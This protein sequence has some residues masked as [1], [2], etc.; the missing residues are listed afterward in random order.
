MGVKKCVHLSDL[1]A[2][3]VSTQNGDTVLVAQ[4]KADE[5]GDGLNRI[6]TAIHIITHEEIIGIRGLSANSKKFDQI[7]PL[8]VNVST[9]SHRAANRLHI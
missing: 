3:V 2:L 1:S 7:V 9:N 8:S 5:Q 4:L 6:V